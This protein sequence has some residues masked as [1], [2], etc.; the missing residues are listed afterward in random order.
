MTVS[1]LPGSRLTMDYVTRLFDGGRNQA[2]SSGRAPA[3]APSPESDRTQRAI[4]KIVSILMESRGFDQSVTVHATGLVSA[5]TGDGNDSLFIDA[6]ETFSVTTGDGDDRVVISASGRQYPA[7]SP[8][9]HEAH[10][11]V[12]GGGAGNDTVL[13]DAR[14]GISRVEGGDGNDVI[15]T[16]SFTA[17][18][19]EGGAGRDKIA[20]SA[21]QRINIVDG[22]D[23]DDIITVEAPEIS[24]IIGGN[25]NDTIDVTGESVKMSMGGRGDDKLNLDIRGGRAALL[26]AA[27]GDGHDTIE[28]NAAL[29]IRR[30]S[31]DGTRN[32]S[33]AASVTQNDDGTLTLGFAGSN[34]TVTVKFTGAMQGK[35]IVV[36]YDDNEGWL[37]VRAKDEAARTPWSD[38]RTITNI[39]ATP[40]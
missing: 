16:R 23:G 29:I 5:T 19:I 3:L 14:D 26:V 2:A 28:S 39:N 6:E 10:I 18:L 34:D 25:G 36:E 17:Y 8:R 1:P 20:V 31:E 12:V 13:L 32:A 40:Y 15:A 37:V 38:A 24:G 27:E 4:G 35:E 33:A 30:V 22:G 7:H 21:E 9:G 11:D